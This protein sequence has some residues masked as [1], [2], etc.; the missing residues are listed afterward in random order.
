MENQA[1]SKGTILNYGL[2]LGIAGVFI[3]L[4]FY[5]TGNLISLGWLSGIIGFIAMIILIILGIK[6]F[7]ADNG[8][9]LTFGQAVKVGVGIAVISGII[10]TIY[11]LIFTNV[12][13]PTIQEQALEI[14]RQAWID[15][16]YNEDQMEASEAMMQKMQSPMI[17]VPLSI[18]ISAFFGFVIS[19]IGGAIMK[20]TEENQY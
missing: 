14:Q 9:F 2:Y 17:T 1:N 7:K 16:G 5:A 18:V 15:A 6:K 11:T 10:S 12:I 13:D 4:I 19:A 8:G 20:K 3:H